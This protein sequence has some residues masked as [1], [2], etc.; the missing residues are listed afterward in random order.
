MSLVLAGPKASYFPF[1]LKDGKTYLDDAEL[2]GF[3]KYPLHKTIKNSELNE[4]NT[5]IETTIK[6]IP[7]STKF[8]G[9]IRYYNLKKAEIGALLSAIS[10]HGHNDLLD[11]NLGSAKPLGYGRIAIK[12]IN[13]EDS[14][15]YLA[16]FETL[17]Q[18]HAKKILKQ[19]WQDIPALKELY[20]MSI[21][22]V[23]E[24][25]L[26]YP[27]I[28]FSDTKRKDVNEFANYIKNNTYLEDYSKL[29][30][31]KELKFISIRHRWE[32]EQKK[33]EEAEQK[34]QQQEKELNNILSNAEEL[35]YKSYFNQAIIE[36]KRALELRA[37]FDND[38]LQKKIEACKEEIDKIDSQYS[39]IISKADNEYGNKNWETAK[40]LY[41][42]AIEL[43]PGEEFPKQQK[44]RCLKELDK[45]SVSLQLIKDF[46]DFNKAKKIIENYYKSTGNVEVADKEQI[47][48]LKSFVSRCI[49]KSNKRWKRSGDKDWKLVI[50][51][52]GS[53][54]AQ[55]WFDEFIK[56]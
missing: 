36:Y 34:R 54:T 55:Q 13:C 40:E 7:E 17:V 35:F 1:Y 48:L 10:F 26:K 29:Y 18:N 21:D 41:L 5:E 24:F 50:K 44:N 6:P 15:R 3:K 45:T 27:K 39:T 30:Q 8:R 46:N 22:P 9:K 47:S 2:K 20:A 51:W 19:N 16:E 38:A 25:L 28:E 32:L 42:K 23:K 43:K 14:D 31:G 12:L 37:D 33:H 53:E 56:K 4:T 11:H 49:Q 52:I